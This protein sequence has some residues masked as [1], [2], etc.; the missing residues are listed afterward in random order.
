MCF[1]KWAMHKLQTFFKKEETQQK[2]NECLTQN[3]GE[4]CEFDK[5]C[6]HVNPIRGYREGSVV[7]S[8][9]YSIR[10]GFSCQHP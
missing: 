10:A 3:K 1:L 2:Q 6:T 7:K 8:T 4:F 5:M 9:D